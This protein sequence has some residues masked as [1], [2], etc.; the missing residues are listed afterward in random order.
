MDL[1][2]QLQVCQSKHENHHF[3]LMLKFYNIF[4]W[5]RSEAVG[6]FLSYLSYL[7]IHVIYIFID[8]FIVICYVLLICICSNFGGSVTLDHQL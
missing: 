5:M 3:S 6:S 1:V 8:Y 4:S 7:L 2:L